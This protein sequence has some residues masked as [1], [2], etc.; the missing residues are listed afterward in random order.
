MKYLWAAL[1][2]VSAIVAIAILAIA[3]PV[4][5]LYFTAWL[6]LLRH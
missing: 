3:I 5:T 2:T 6:L 4:L 1:I